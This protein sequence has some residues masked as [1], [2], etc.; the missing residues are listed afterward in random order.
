MKGRRPKNHNS[1]E[2]QIQIGKRIKEMRKAKGFTVPQFAELL[3]VDRVSVHRFESGKFNLSVNTLS[4]IA[5][6]LD[7]DVE[8]I[9][10][11]KSG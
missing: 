5:A 2:L 11:A 4:R 9:L 10:K 1:D 8:V 3:G 7:C 6:A